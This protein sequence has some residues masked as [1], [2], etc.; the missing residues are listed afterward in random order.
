VKYGL[1]ITIK[2]RLFLSH[3]KHIKTIALLTLIASNS[4]G[5]IA[6]SVTEAVNLQNQQTS[7]KH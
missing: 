2:G 4:S 1:D 5:T 6:V 7:A 3:L